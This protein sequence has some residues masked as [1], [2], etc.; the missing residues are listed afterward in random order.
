MLKSKDLL[1]GDEKQPELKAEVKRYWYLGWLWPL[2]RTLKSSNNVTHF[3]PLRS[4][5]QDIYKA[6]ILTA[7]L[8]T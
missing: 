6:W 3:F 8:C 4:N 2:K 5:R 7:V 1:K